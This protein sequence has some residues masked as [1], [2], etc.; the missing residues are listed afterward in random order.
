MKGKA[1]LLLFVFLLNTVVGFSCALHMSHEDH[2]EMVS[3]HDHHHASLAFIG[4]HQLMN[5]ATLTAEVPCCQGAVNNFISQAKL[6]PASGNVLLHTPFVY[7]S[8]IYQYAH[9]LYWSDLHKGALY[10]HPERRRF[11]PDDIRITI[12]SLLI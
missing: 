2:E 1:L 10:S 7:I 12:C 5:K 9:V 6:I 11:P 4:H 8:Y 3:H